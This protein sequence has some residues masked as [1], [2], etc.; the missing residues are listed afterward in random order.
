M[1]CVWNY[2]EKNISMR[3][4]IKGILWSSYIWFKIIFT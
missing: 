3:H 2:V 4:V 1:K